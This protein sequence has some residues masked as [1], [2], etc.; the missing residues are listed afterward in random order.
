[1]GEHT[2]WDFFGL[3]IQSVPSNNHQGMLIFVNI[4]DYFSHL[5]L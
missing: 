2:R 5:L 1:M 3:Y 4:L